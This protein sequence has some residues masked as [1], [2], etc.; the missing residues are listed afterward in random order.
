MENFRT[1]KDGRILIIVALAFLVMPVGVAGISSR[2]YA[3]KEIS[4]MDRFNVAR[5]VE[6]IDADAN[7]EFTSLADHDKRFHGGHYEASQKCKLRESLGRKGGELSDLALTPKI[8]KKFNRAEAREELDKRRKYLDMVFGYNF[9]GVG[10]TTFDD[11]GNSKYRALRNAQN[12]KLAPFGTYDLR[13]G[14]PIEYKTGYQV[15]FQEDTTEALDHDRY[16]SGK[17]YDSLVERL[18]KECNSMPHLGTFGN[19]EISFHVE[20]KDQAM[21]VARRFNQESIYDWSTHG[22]TYECFPNPDR[23]GID[24]FLSGVNEFTDKFKM[25][26]QRNEQKVNN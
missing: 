13:T 17:D 5:L 11:P 23:R 4:I 2:Q 12:K 26:K 3:D 9:E 22:K 15:A 24:H 10:Q 8:Q 20:S 6:W 16:I 21:A 18:S 1:I 25:R 7:D 14:R 19:P